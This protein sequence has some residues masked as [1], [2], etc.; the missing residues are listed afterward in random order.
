MK[1][2]IIQPPFVQLNTPYPSGAYLSAYFKKQG[3]SV[4]WYD[5][6][7]ALFNKIF[8]RA[9]L[10]KLF[11]LSSSKALNLADI[12][13]KKGDSETAFNLRRYISESSEWIQWIDTITAILRSRTS[14]R[15]LNHSFVF[16]AFTPRGA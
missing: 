1:V 12:A 10:A 9:G 14:T 11:S 15:E 5:L 4:Q 16:G 8:S 13:E 3:H 6:S 2:I 7:L